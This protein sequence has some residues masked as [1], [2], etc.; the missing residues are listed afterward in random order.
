[1]FMIEISFYLGII[2]APHAWKL[3]EFYTAFDLLLCGVAMATYLGETC[4]AIY[5]EIYFV[6]RRNN[7][8]INA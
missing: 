2:P 4:I 8:S 7:G 6:E 3:Q 5:K 1:M